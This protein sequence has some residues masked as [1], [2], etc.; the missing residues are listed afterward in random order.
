MI[1]CIAVDDESLTL[2]IIEKYVKMAPDLELMARCSGPVEALK[3]LN[4][5]QV[6]LMFL[7]IRM[8]ELSGIQFLKSLENPSIVIFTTAYEQYAL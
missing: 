5:N 2:V 6:D 7:D 4:E 3:F 1:K 8:S